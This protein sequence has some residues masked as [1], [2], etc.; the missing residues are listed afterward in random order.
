MTNRPKQQSSPFS[1]G[2]GGY[3]FEH[4][5]QTAFAVYM[6]SGGYVPGLP[7]WPIQ[8]I[9]LQGRIAGY[10]TDDCIIEVQDPQNHE[11][12]RKQLISIKHE[13]S[14]TKTDSNF[15]EVI[16]AAWQDFKNPEVF[17]QGRDSI[18]LV[19]GPLK[20]A[21]IDHVRPL[22]EWARTSATGIEFFTKVETGGFSSE[23]KRKKLSVLKYAIFEASE[24]DQ[25]DDEEI[26]EF[27][28]C[29]NLY[30]YDLDQSSGSH[31]S[32]LKGM[33]WLA[34]LEDSNPD[35]IWAQ[36]LEF[37]SQSDA[38]S[39][40]LTVATIPD[41]IKSHFLPN[42]RIGD[43]ADI[44]RLKDHGDYILRPI[45][46]KI[47]EAHIDRQ[48]FID[49][50]VDLS[51]SSNFIFVTGPRGCGKSAVIKE[52]AQHIKDRYPVYCLRAED[53]DKSHLDAVF[54]AIGI[55]LTLKEL[56]HRFASMPNRYLILES[57][58]KVLELEYPYAFINLLNFLQESPGWTVI[59]S[60]RD[61][62][63][64]QIC[65]HYLDLLKVHWSPIVVADFTDDEY[66]NLSEK[67]PLFEHFKGNN[68]I[69]PLLK[70]PFLADLAYRVLK[71][72]TRFNP[73]DGELAFRNAVWQDVIRD[74]SHRAGGLHLKRGITFSEVA[75]KR[76]REMRFGIEADQF[77]VEALASLEHDGLIFRDSNT[78]LVGP[79]H[80]VL[81]D[82]AIENHIE[83][84]YREHAGSLSNF[85]DEIGHE[86]AMLRAFRLWLHFKLRVDE[87]TADLKSFIHSS[88]QP[89]VLPTGVQNE[90]I[91]AILKGEDPFGLLCMLHETLF[92]NDAELLKRFCF[93]LRLTCKAPSPFYSQLAGEAYKKAV[94]FLFLAPHGNGWNAIIY[95]LFKY[96]E[97]APEELT[98]HIL[99]VLSEWSINVNIKDEPSETHHK[100]G[101][102]A[103]CILN[104]LKHGYGPDTH[105]ALLKII[106]RVVESI[107]LEFREVMEADVFGESDAQGKGPLP[108]VDKLCEMGLLG[109]DSVFLSKHIPDLVERLGWQTWL[110]SDNGKKDH[111]NPMDIEVYF[112]LE[113]Y[114]HGA[115]FFP[116]SGI[117]GPFHAL[118]RW[119]PN[120]GL[121]F[122]IKLC[123]YAA[124]K[125]MKSGLDSGAKTTVELELNDGKV[126]LKHCSERLWFG[127]RSTSVLPYLLQ[128]GLMALENWLIE[129]AENEVE[130]NLLD[131]IDYIFRNR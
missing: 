89:A 21:D 121:D 51:E 76:A 40:T 33:I 87:D 86:P 116:P 83:S 93:M 5:V 42:V 26:W 3:T 32:L 105:E 120:R 20:K 119:N 102:I 79:A 2:G 64:Q 81:E 31:L 70:N 101:L 78:N 63:Y 46:L 58:E 118:L 71:S 66:Q 80:D 72:G 127:Y 15:R 1:T 10:E 38:S 75:L 92:E 30:G 108:Y 52:F 111:Y 106:F 95:F 4:C 98:P 123:N 88:L 50:I 65:F 57:L 14:I 49:K 39:G 22:L 110:L 55:N 124:E 27:L 47:G 9:K 48:H 67:E 117:K 77:D 96:L 29:F 61:Y 125:Y 82:W 8:K 100:V 99:P 113:H 85:M 126:V 69:L 59:A 128:S 104:K 62:A 60:G 56:S 35:A 34:S 12:V 131:V 6:L 37:V 43:T 17:T 73:S 18:A 36:L 7:L 114:G 24:G 74:E 94:E 115:D 44:R 91:T 54:T 90:V 19:T 53:L 28:K 11:K 129:L 23:Q 130:T 103:L 13:V 45:I 112:G 84:A 68:N 25:V 16:R 97:E 122:I 109:L 41:G 107:E